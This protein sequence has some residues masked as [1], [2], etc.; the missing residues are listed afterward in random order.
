MRQTEAIGLV[1]VI[2]HACR[3]GIPIFSRNPSDRTL[4]TAEPP[5]GMA[6]NE[7][8][9]RPSSSGST[10]I[11]MVGTPAATVTRSDSIRPASVGA[12]R[13]A[14]GM[15]RLAP[16]ATAAWARPHALAWNMGTT[17]RMVS[18]SIAPRLS[19]C[20]APIVCNQVERWEYTTPLG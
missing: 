10:P 2:P 7:V 18:L 6:R 20:M 4:G 16:Q 15:T 8:T 3:I 19:A 12:E 9:S 11:Q 14:P 13:S 5:Q 17:G 1:S